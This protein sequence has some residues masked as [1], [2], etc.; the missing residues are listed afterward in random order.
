M[1][2]H[3]ENT[4]SLSIP[5]WDAL[6]GWIRRE[7]QRRLQEILEEE[8]TGFLGRCPY[9]R[10]SGVDSHS[11]YRNWYGK[12]RR[13]RLTGGT[14]EVKRPRIRDLEER[15][16]SRVLP[17]FARRTKQVG[18]LL[19]E[20]YLHGLSLGDCELALRGLLGDGAPLSQSSIS[21][22]TAKWEYGAP[23]LA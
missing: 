7:I 23:D 4:P 11:G 20:L 3:T 22:L 14:I 6:E 9:E 21:R 1:Q 12:P 18:D 5:V 15:F 17:L 2:K 16:E 10:R 19:P 13:L 8:V